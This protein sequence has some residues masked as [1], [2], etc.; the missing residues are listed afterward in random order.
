MHPG[1]RRRRKRF[2]SKSTSNILRRHNSFNTT[3]TLHS[4][5]IIEPSSRMYSNTLYKF[6]L[7]PITFNQPQP[8]LHRRITIQPI[9]EAEEIKNERRKGNRANVITFN[10]HRSSMDEGSV[11][12]ERPGSWV[13][14]KESIGEKCAKNLRGP[15]EDQWQG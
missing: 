4:L 7:H 3:K 11:P 14:I 12:I 5:P 9:R 10:H 13:E 15:A 2:I 1:N 8:F 6:T